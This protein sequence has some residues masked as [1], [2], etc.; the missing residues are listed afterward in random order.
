MNERKTHGANQLLDAIG[1]VHDVWIQEAIVYKPARRMQKLSILITAACLAL[2]L[3]LTP[4]VLRLL[5]N[6]PDDPA[7]P[8]R[9]ETTVDAF[10]A[11]NRTHFEQGGESLVTCLSSAE[12]LDFFGGEAHVVW[13]YV[14]DDKLYVSRK[15]TSSEIKILTEEIDRAKPV[16]AVSPDLACRVWIIFGNGEVI[17]PYLPNTD[18]NTAQAMLFDYE[19]ELVPTDRF[20]SC[21]SELITEH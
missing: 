18:G 7:A 4:S 11:D 5:K 13:Q 20:L 14:N 12:E 3:A 17:S 10:L 15:L 19:A 2:I 16:G 21:I 1:D 9:R 8:P 6:A